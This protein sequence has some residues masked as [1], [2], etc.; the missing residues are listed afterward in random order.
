MLLGRRLN[1]AFTIPLGKSKV[2]MK[3]QGMITGVINH[4]FSDYSIHMRFDKLLSKMITDELALTTAV[5]SKGD[6]K[7]DK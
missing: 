2:E 1:V 6:T 5:K 4:L 7:T 3:Q